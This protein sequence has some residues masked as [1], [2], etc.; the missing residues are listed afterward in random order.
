VTDA[1]IS[2][3]TT[4]VIVLGTGAAGLVAALATREAGVSVELFEKTDAVG[5]TTAISGGTCWVPDHA[6]GGFDPADER[7]RAMAYLASLSHGFI[8]DELAAALI[9]HGP[10][11]F[12][13][14]ESVTDFGD[15]GSRGLP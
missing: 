11:V 2:S 14:I 8:R 7:Q 6:H 1:G 10:Q 3:R 15:F 4:D 9:D 5:G 13:W 12:E